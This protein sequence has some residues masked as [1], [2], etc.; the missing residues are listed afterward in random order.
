MAEADQVIAEAREHAARIRED[1]ERELA[2]ATAQRDNINSQLAN[3]R[4]MLASFGMGSVE[5]PEDVTAGP[6]TPQ[7][8]AAEANPTDERH[9]KA[10]AEV[11]APEQGDE[12]PAEDGDKGGEDAQDAQRTVNGQPVRAGQPNDQN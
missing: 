2:A 3:V 8:P 11:A 10:R 6:K 4:Q 7:A 12:S 5:I 9:Q 1:S